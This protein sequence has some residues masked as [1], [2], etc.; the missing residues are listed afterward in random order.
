MIEA[1][2]FGCIG[3]PGHYWWRRDR[4]D[5]GI[6]KIVGPNIDPRIDAGF[7]PGTSRDLKPWQRTRP[8]VEGE[9]AMHHIDGWTVLAFWDRSVD[10]RGA[11]NSNFVAR[12]EHDFD[13]MLAIAREQFPHVMG[14]L[15]FEV[16]LA[17]GF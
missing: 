2:Y 17:E 10:R 1:Y 15:S 14:R 11:C 8:E 13:A 4:C 6:P 9:A 5:W 16:K 3:H 12:G 7:C